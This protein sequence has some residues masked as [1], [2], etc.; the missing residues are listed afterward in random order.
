[1]G[2]YRHKTHNSQVSA[3]VV[4]AMGL[5][6]RF[7]RIWVTAIVINYSCVLMMSKV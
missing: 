3:M 2:R 7:L 4:V 1:M 5:F 6:C